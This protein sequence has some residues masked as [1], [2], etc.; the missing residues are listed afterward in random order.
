MID[1]LHGLVEKKTATHAVIFVNGIGYKVMMS[2]NGLE[3]LPAKGGDAIVLTYLHVREDIL[4]LYGF[5]DEK[6]RNV[7][8][9]LT[10]ISGIGPKLAL[11]I[12]SG[13][14]PSRLKDRVIAGDV[15]SLTS[16]PGV[17]PKTAKRIIVELKEK[18]IKTDDDSLGFEDGEGSGS[19][20]FRDVVNALTSL[21]YKTNHA[22][23]AC[24]ELEKK[25]ELSGEL[26]SVIKKALNQLM[27]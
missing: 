26:E 12:L 3:S 16:V 17:G 6:E 14:E 1:Q 8:H 2:I 22:K 15:A 11:T 24:T 23:N 7:F 27:S 5:V 25:G 13:I 10:S 21:G 4:N 19:Q 9:L 20:L 18:F